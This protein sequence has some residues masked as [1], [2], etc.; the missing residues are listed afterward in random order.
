M[1]LSIDPSCAES[2]FT[3]AVA[4]PQ[5]RSNHTLYNWRYPV[6][7]VTTSSCAKL[8]VSVRLAFTLDWSV[9][10]GCCKPLLTVSSSQRYLCKSF[11]RCLTPYPG[12]LWSAFSHFFLLSIGLPLWAKESA[13]T[14]LSIQQLQY[15]P[16]FGTVGIRFCSNL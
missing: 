10:A 12:V 2:S 11:F 15:G 4:L 5:Q 16:Y 14:Q 8:I 9:R 3:S 13:L 6:I 7:I 1:K